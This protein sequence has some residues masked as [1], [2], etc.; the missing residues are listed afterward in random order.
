MNL[1]S[2]LTESEAAPAFA[3][4]LK[5]AEKHVRSELAS[6]FR[7]KPKFEVKVISPYKATMTLDMQQF[8]HP[9]DIDAVAEDFK[10]A[11]KQADTESH[12]FKIEDG[13]SHGSNFVEAILGGLRPGMTV[14]AE[15]FFPTIEYEIT[16]KQI[17]KK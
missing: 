5:K 11:L 9:Q 3:K 2:F 14:K 13:A 7:T 10:F 1:K 12:V 16:F 15:A 4:Y 6:T 8:M 17:M